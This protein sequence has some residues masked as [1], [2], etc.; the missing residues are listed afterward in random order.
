MELAHQRHWPSVPIG[1]MISRCLALLSHVYPYV[2]QR[3]PESIRSELH[4]RSIGSERVWRSGD[5]VYKS[6]SIPF[7]DMETVTD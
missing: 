6:V 3:C 4:W 1:R 7:T 2:H 5:V